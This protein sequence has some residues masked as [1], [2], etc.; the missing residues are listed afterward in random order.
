MPRQLILLIV[1]AVLYVEAAF[2]R[3]APPAVRKDAA[4]GSNKTFRTM[5]AAID[6]LQAAAHGDQAIFVYPGTYTEQVVIDLPASVTKLSI[7]GYTADTS[8][9][10]GNT[11]T[12]AYGRG[13][14]SG[15]TDDGSGTLRILSP[16]VAV[17]NLNV[18]NTRGQGDQALAVSAQQPRTAFYGVQ[19]S[20][21]QDT[22]Y[23]NG[24]GAQVYARSRIVGA[25]D[26]IF[27]RA[28]AWF[29][30]VQLEVTAS[31]FV[32]ASGRDSPTD[33]SWIV[34]DRCSVAA[35]PSAPAGTSAMLGRPWRDDARVVFQN[36]Y[37]GA[38]INPSGWTPFHPGQDLSH[39]Y[40][41]EYNNSGPGSNMAKRVSWAQPPLK[42]AVDIKT[43]LGSDYAT[44]VDTSYL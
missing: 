40:Y 30:D 5:Q 19:L 37:L 36:T 25:V 21:F 4:Q 13:A 9:Y 22:L 20:G 17:Y 35:A 16:N 11:V 44:W 32:T 24:N 18:A 2:S 6:A 12:L 31:G 33:K 34:F 14:G 38:V 43:V 39:V 7:Y 28:S 23:A 8:S 10:T 27:G 29:T 1:L 41:G 26:F 15:V 42:S 3:T